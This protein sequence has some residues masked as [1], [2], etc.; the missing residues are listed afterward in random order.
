MGNH[1]VLTVYDPMPTRR[2]HDIPIDK[3]LGKSIFNIAIKDR[4]SMEYPEPNKC[5]SEA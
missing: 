4:K 2:D 1:A 5:Y 3:K